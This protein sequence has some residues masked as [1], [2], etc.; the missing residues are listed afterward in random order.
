MPR[1]PNGEKR[2]AGQGACAITVAKIAA[3]ELPE[4]SIAHKGKDLRIPNTTPEQ[5]AETLMRGGAKPRPE[6]KGRKTS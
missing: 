1:G 4:D 3:G 6:T 5:L 2:P